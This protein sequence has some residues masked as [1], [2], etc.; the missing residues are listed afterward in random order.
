MGDG[1]KMQ[2]LVPLYVW[3]K[4]NFYLHKEKLGIFLNAL[5]LRPNVMP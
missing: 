4:V 5:S 1:F 3:L 2:E